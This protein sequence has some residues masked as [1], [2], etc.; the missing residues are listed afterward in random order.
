MSL[1]LLLAAIAEPALNTPSEVPAHLQAAWVAC[2]N[3]KLDFSSE[4]FANEIEGCEAL[5]KAKDVDSEVKAIAH[6]NR[7]MLMAQASF[8]VTAKDELDEAVELNPKLAPAYYNRALVLEATGDPKGAIADYS[9]AIEI[10]PKMAEAFI[11]RGIARAK[12]GDLAPALADF[13]KA[14]ELEPTDAD[15]YENRAH[16]LHQM[17]RQNEAEA[18]MV[19]AKDLAKE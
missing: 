5:I 16:L 15:L 7:G 4:G 9:A 1:L 18:D 13:N 8:L 12:I 10:N 11:N 17:G 19:K 14:I 2:R 6:T 3:E